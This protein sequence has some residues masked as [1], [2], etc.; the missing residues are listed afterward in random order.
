MLVQLQQIN[1]LERQD[2]ILVADTLQVVVLVE[3]KD[4]MNLRVEQVVV[5]TEG[6]VEQ[7]LHLLSIKA[8]HQLEG[9]EVEVDLLEVLVLLESAINVQLLL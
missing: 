3:L 1:Q 5:L 7:L 9:A 6:I 8:L 4:Q 2:Q